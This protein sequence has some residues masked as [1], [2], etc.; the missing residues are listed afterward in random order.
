MIPK[1]LFTQL[2]ENIIDTRYSD[3][4]SYTR[5]EK[6]VKHVLENLI[7]NTPFEASWTLGGTLGG[8][9]SDEKISVAPE[10]EPELDN[11]DDFLLK[12]YP[13]C[14][15]LQYKKIIQKT[16]LT[17]HQDSDYYGGSTTQANKKLNI[18]DLSDVLLNFN[19]I[20]KEEPLVEFNIENALT[21]YNENLKPSYEAIHNKKNVSK[22]NRN[23]K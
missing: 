4:I 5:F 20:S 1:I 9:S 2:I 7:K 21:I 19:L 22:K 15:F 18:H 16:N 3:S 10:V 17:Q 13:T 14:S 12:Y 8:Y 6:D 11:L 23:K